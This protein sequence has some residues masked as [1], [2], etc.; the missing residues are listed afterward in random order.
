MQ[1]HSIRT[2][3]STRKKQTQLLLMTMFA[4]FVPAFHFAA[5]EQDKPP[6]GR[7]KPISS[8]RVA[9]E[10]SPASGVEDSGSLRPDSPSR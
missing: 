4:V 5:Q 3:L 2:K 8:R 1:L 9:Y 7:G 6:E 10:A